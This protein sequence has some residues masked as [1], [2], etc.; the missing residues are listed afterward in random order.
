[1][2]SVILQHILEYSALMQITDTTLRG[3][4]KIFAKFSTPLE[5]ATNKKTEDKRLLKH[6]LSAQY[7]TNS[8]IRILSQKKKTS[9]TVTREINHV[10]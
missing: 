9:N 3:R 2:Y 5:P 8:R 4:V 6:P 7:H 10:Y 1:M